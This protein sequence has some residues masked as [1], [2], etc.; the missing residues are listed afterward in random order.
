M[1]QHEIHPVIPDHQIFLE[2]S[3]H[4]RS[5]MIRNKLKVVGVPMT[6]LMIFWVNRIIFQPRDLSEIVVGFPMTQPPFGSF[7]YITSPQITIIYV[8]PGVS[9]FELCH[10]KASYVRWSKEAD[11][12][13]WSSHSVTRNTT[14][15]YINPNWSSRVRDLKNGVST[16]RFFNY[17]NFGHPQQLQDH[18]L[19]WFN[20]QEG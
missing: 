13:S 8:W 17:F 3:S 19:L 15:E 20:F 14:R 4:H 11:E 12:C 16:A 1:G 9:A 6:H 7:W 10:L 2:A 18:L 5:E